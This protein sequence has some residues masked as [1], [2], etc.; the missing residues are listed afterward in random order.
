MSKVRVEGV[1]AGAGRRFRWSSGFS[2]RGSAKGLSSNFGCPRIPHNRYIIVP[3]F[4]RLGFNGKGEQSRCLSRR[5]ASA[6]RF[7]SKY[8]LDSFAMQCPKIPTSS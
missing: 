4:G 3:C 1:E 7:L 8:L 5:T 2:R 6:A